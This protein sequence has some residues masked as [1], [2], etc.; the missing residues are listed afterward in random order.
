VIEPGGDEALVALSDG[1]G[2]PLGPA[3]SRRGYV[4]GTFFHAIAMGK[5]AP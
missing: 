3:G 4:S 1:Q 5:P 2:A